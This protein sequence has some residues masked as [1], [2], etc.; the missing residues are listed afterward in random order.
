MGINRGTFVLKFLK[1][2]DEMPIIEYNTIC[3]IMLNKVMIPIISKEQLLIRPFYRRIICV[4]ALIIILGSPCLQAEDSRRDTRSGL[5]VIWYPEDKKELFLGHPLIKGGQIVFQWKDVEPKKGHYDFSVISEKLK[6]F[7]HQGQSATIQINGNEK[8]DWL[9]EKVPFVREKFHHQ[10]RDRNATLMYWHPTFKNAYLELID[11]FAQHI[12]K[13]S[14]QDSILGVRLNFNAVGTEAVGVPAE[15]RSLD[16][17]ILPEGIE[18]KDLQ[19]WS[20]DVAKNYRKAVVETFLKSFENVGRVFVRNNVEDELVAAFRKDIDQGKIGW[21]HTS[22]EAEPRNTSAERKYRRFYDDCR[23]G[24]TSA[25]AEPWA[26]AWGHH[27]GKTDDRWCSPQQW[28][29]WRLLLDMHCGVSFIAI[30]STDFRVGIDGEYPL[31]S[32]TAGGYD[33]GRGSAIQKEFEEAFKFAAKYVGY[34]AEPKRSPG[35][36]IAFRENNTVLAANGIPSTQRR[37]NFFNTDYTFLMKRINGDASSGQ[38]VTNIGPDEQRFG[39]WARILPEGG[40][41]QLAL[42]DKFVESLSGGNIDIRLIYYDDGKGSFKVQVKD[43]VFRKKISGS[44]TWKYADFKEDGG[45]LKKG[46]SGEHITVFAEKG[47]LAIH[48]VE[49]TRK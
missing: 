44:R 4:F 16:K 41:M 5:Y 34:H 29:Y 31:K 6:D 23:S 8:P 24:K 14:Y 45:M 17:W 18:K 25:Y 42:D 12:Q 15:Y 47:P 40:S 38:N 1:I 22:S 27:G 36:W 39:A 46:S 49:V 11:A 26:S 20:S 7:Y 28:I 3:M 2:V 48:M 32:L 37:L 10:I 19:P 21:F 33:F 9:Y 13:S 43:K 35:A 30:Y